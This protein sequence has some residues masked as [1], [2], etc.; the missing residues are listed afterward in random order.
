[1]KNV[2]AL[3][4][5]FVASCLYLYVGLCV[6]EQWFNSR[7]EAHEVAFSDELKW[8]AAANACLALAYGLVWL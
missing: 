6:L 3:L 7:H 8:A 4:L 5:V 2:T 1:M